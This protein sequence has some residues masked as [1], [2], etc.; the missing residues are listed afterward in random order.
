MASVKH[1]IFANLSGNVWTALMGFL[2]V[3]IYLHFLGAE[4]FG[5][6]GF[7]TTISGIVSLM[8]AGFG[9]AANRQFAR[10]DLTAQRDCVAARSLARSLEWLFWGA[11][12]AASGDTVAL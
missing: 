1:N 4:G 7:F 3:P 9:G 12:K 5:L 6:I 8:D 2:F 10:L 11:A